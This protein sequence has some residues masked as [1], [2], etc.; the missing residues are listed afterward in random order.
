MKGKILIGL[1]LFTISNSIVVAQ[2]FYGFGQI[3]IDEKENFSINR[4]RV[5]IKGPLE[6]GILGLGVSYDLYADFNN[7]GLPSLGFGYITFNFGKEWT[8]EIDIGMRLD[9]MT[10]QFPA[11]FQIPVLKYPA[12]FLINPCETG[13]FVRKDYKRLWAMIG[14][15]NGS[16]DYKDNNQS[17]DFTS[18]ATY[19]LPWG[20]VVGG[21]FRD[22]KQPDG[23]RRVYG[24]DLSWRSGSIWINTGQNIRDYNGQNIGRW[25]WSTID[26]WPWFQL[27]GLVE[28]LKMHEKTSSGWSAG[29][30]IIPTKNT[31]IR[32]NIYDMAKDDKEE[33]CWGVLFQ[34]IF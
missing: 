7:T 24:G 31:V 21:V 26:I 22:G 2:D 30:N 3:K 11:P 18:R 15:V 14:V 8:P 34:R 25:L 32:L 27:V 9:P 17:L 6:Q 5:G 28:E 4:F 1:I 12:A 33:T 10:Y 16:G 13:I 19:E 29:I 20:F 23:N